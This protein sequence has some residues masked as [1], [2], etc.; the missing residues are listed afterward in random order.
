MKLFPALERFNRIT[1]LD[2]EYSAPPGE[3][4]SP[5][6]FVAIDL[7]TGRVTRGFVRDFSTPPYGIDSDSLVVT[8]YASAE[9]SCHL[10]LGWSV[11]ANI[12]DLFCEFRW[13]TNHGAERQPA[14]LLDALTYFGIDSI[15][16]NEK[17]EMRQLAIRGEPFTPS[18]QVALLDY[19]ESDVRALEKL[20]PAMLD[21][22]LDLERALLRGQYMAAAARVEANGIPVDVEKYSLFQK[23]W[24]LIQ[25]RLVEKVNIEFDVYDGTSFRQK[26]FRD[27]LQAKGIR[28]PTLQSGSLDLTDETFKT[29][30]IGHPDLAK[31]REVRLVLS[32]MRLNDLAV[33]SDGRNRC[34]LS[35]FASKT[36]RN[37]PS[38]SK[39]A[40]GQASW[41]RNLIQ[42]KPGTALA[43]VDWEQ[44]EFGTAG[45]LSK[46]QRMMEAYTS[47]DPYLTFGKQAGVI[48]RD[49]TKKTH[50]HQRDQFKQ[51]ALGVQYG[52]GEKS[53]ALQL[54][55]SI[56]HGKE[57]LALHKRTYPKFWSWQEAIIADARSKNVVRT[58]FG[59][60]MRVNKQ[61]GIR[62]IANFPIQANGAEMLRLAIIFATQKGVKV[63]APVHDAL[64][65]EANESEIDQAVQVTQNCMREASK[66]VLG[67]FELRS[68]VKVIRYPDRYDD[69]RGTE[70]WR[71][72][73]EI[74]KELEAEIPVAD[75][76]D[77]LKRGPVQSFIYPLENRP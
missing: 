38:N 16:S 41:L 43:Y 68:D 46:D 21:R 6:C 55:Q 30:A 49:G 77:V 2:F 52:M 28:W 33:G 3:I 19:C 4:P 67:G 36:G 23:H 62:T 44:Q 17:E 26:K 31:L 54:G 60:R 50:G 35:A 45:A 32:K 18:E 61:T 66:V 1:C 76:L 24:K 34:L 29:M 59:W 37:Q 74:V 70:I 22:G 27:Y 48:P 72:V 7:L 5:H 9:I 40:F 71:Q 63:C 20:L 51:A 14:S 11:P 57:L 39:F 12:L 65:I 73:L 25:R 64:L 56:A 58:V 42:P 13:L 47:G 8:Y 75:E 69:P 15:G 53:L 10:D